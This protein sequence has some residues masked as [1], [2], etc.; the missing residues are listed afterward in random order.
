L[1]KSKHLAVLCRAQWRRRKRKSPAALTHRALWLL[2]FGSLDLE[3]FIPAR[4]VWAICLGANAM[5][6]PSQ[7]GHRIEARPDATLAPA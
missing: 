5:R 2:F 6:P 7:F 1:L 4:C 3:S